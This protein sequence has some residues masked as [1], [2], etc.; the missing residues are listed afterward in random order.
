MEEGSQGGRGKPGGGWRGAC[1]T[2]A[3]AV[4]VERRASVSRG[5]LH[6][7]IHPDPSELQQNTDAWPYPRHTGSQSPG[8]S[9]AS[10]YFRSTK[11]ILAIPPEGK[12]TAKEKTHVQEGLGAKEEEMKKIMLQFL[13]GPPEWRAGMWARTH[14][15]S[16]GT[17]P[18]AGGKFTPSRTSRERHACSVV[19]EKWGSELQPKLWLK[20][21]AAGCWERFPRRV[22]RSWARG[23][24]R[25]NR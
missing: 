22:F 16:K 17:S 10:W 12:D 19:R 23:N 13:T 7:A 24:P 8:W 18:A 25:L 1:L 5:L 9:A 3:G 21:W 11:V 2:R 6:L 20:P 4:E 14:W 15:R